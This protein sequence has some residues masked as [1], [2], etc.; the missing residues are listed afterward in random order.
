MSRSILISALLAV[1]FLGCAT[2]PKVDPNINW[3]GRIGSYSYDQARA[4]LG[5]PDM[6][7]GLSDGSQ[8]AEWITKQSPQMSY[9]VGL[10]TGV[11]GRNSGGGVGV[12]TTVSPP[13]HGE[14]LS[15]TF[16]PD[17]KLKQWGRGR[18]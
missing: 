2:H 11:F 5:Q 16:G 13:P 18:H 17:G 8:T 14:Y 6:V 1:V 15:L 12:G 7:A 10:N 4:E 3:N 9:G